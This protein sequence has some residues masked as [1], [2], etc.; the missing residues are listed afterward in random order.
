MDQPTIYDVIHSEKGKEKQTS[1]IN[2]LNP[3]KERY[4]TRN[5]SLLG[6]HVV[7]EDDLERAW[8]D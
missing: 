8:E 4:P 2:L 3:C 6:W 1:H 7:E 5:T